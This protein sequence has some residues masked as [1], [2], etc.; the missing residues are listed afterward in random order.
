MPSPG[1]RILIIIK[2]KYTGTMKK[3]IVFLLSVAMLLPLGLHARKPSGP[4]SLSVMSYNIRYGAA[5][6]GTNSWRYR[7]P[8][9]IYMLREHKPDI[10]GVQEAL[11]FQIKFITEN[12]N[13]YK[14]VG[15]GREDGKF[16]GEHMSIFYNKK[17]IS[18]LKWGTFWLSE[19]P[20]EPSKGWDA[21]C[22]RSATWALMKCKESGKKFFYVNTH[23][24][25]VGEVAQ[26]EGLAVV[27]NYIREMN[28]DNLPMVLTG[29]F[30]VKSDNPVLSDLNKI[31]K[32]AR[33]YAEKT[34]NL[35]SFNGW[36]RS[37]QIIDYIYYSGFS[38]CTEFQTI[39]KKYAE[40]PFISDHYPIKAILI[41]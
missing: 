34:D 19:T 6:D 33:V 17:K 23:L 5:D 24:D 39:Q 15:V 29:D 41:F 20:E 22:F 4:A 38:S 8:A 27:V 36:G 37:K 16:E 2:I 31:M 10:F 26:K 40:R 13:E 14:S 1:V 9:T 18:L 35:N 32:D 12:M 25:H 11:D 3:I 21:A 30:N 7:C 28:P